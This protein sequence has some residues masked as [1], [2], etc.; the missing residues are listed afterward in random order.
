VWWLVA[1]L[2]GSIWGGAGEV[3]IYNQRHAGLTMFRGSAVGPDRV[4]IV[5]DDGEDRHGSILGRDRHKPAPEA[6][7]RSAAVVHWLAGVA[8][9][10]L[11][12]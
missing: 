1:G 12:Y 9:G 5:Y 3:R 7:R 11:G 4:C 10:A 6:C 2:G 8:E